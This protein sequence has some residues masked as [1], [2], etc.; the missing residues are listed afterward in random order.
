MAVAD[1]EAV[2]WHYYHLV[3]L[4][5]TCY[6]GIPI[7]MLHA[8]SMLMG[9]SEGRAAVSSHVR[10]L[11]PPQLPPLKKNFDDDKVPSEH[12]CQYVIY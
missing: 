10:A 4:R 2:R 1:H 7:C 6:S 9:G 12:L 3:L 5:C 8:C 11:A